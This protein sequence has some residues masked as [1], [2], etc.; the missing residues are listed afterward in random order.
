MPRVKE[1][2]MKVVQEAND[3]GGRL[4]TGNTHCFQYFIQLR[5]SV[6]VVDILQTKRSNL[7][8]VAF[9]EYRYVR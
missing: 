8:L 7:S 1:E 6:V 2:I 9:Q 4:L 3:V 5:I